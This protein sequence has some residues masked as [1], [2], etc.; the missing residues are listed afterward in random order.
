MD[1][2]YD[3]CK[4]MSFGNRKLPM[5]QHLISTGKEDISVKKVCEQLN[6]GVL[7]TLD[8]KFGSHIHHILQKANR[9]IGLIKQAFEFLD[10]SML[11]TSYTS[12]VHP[13]L[14]YA[15]VVWCPF[16]WEI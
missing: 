11:Q 12:L 13:Y 14:D 10:A 5:S 8:F 15:C 4:C 7:F 9:L 1:L 6:S 3:K 16:N 2:N